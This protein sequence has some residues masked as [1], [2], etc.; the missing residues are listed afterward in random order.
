[1]F[2]IFKIIMTISAI[3]MAVIFCGITMVVFMAK[4]AKWLCKKVL[5]EEF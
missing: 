5:G 3:L 1:M 2:E 4:Y